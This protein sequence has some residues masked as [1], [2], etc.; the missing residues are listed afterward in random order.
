MVDKID[1]LQEIAGGH[2]VLKQK[3][4][5]LGTELSNPRQHVRDNVQA[6]R[7]RCDTADKKTIAELEKKFAALRE[8]TKRAR[9][10]SA[11]AQRSATK[12]KN[13]WEVHCEADFR[14]LQDRVGLEHSKMDHIKEKLRHM[15]RHM[16]ENANQISS[17]MGDANKVP[18]LL[19]G[20]EQKTTALAKTSRKPFR[21]RQLAHQKAVARLRGEGAL[22]FR[23]SQT[24]MR[25]CWRKKWWGQRWQLNE[26]H[27]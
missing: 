17:L 16:T 4:S 1:I 27:S 20:L 26:W 24:I 11:A 2:A 19:E 9:A 7:A 22:W 15:R 12:A 3:V 18:S 6:E 10:E 23:M 8:S 14:S 25:G 21:T 5:A 13:H